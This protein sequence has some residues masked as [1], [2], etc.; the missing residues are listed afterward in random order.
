MSKR[1]VLCTD[2][3]WDNTGNDTNVYKVST[4]VLNTGDQVAFYDDGVGANG[5]IIEKLAGGALGA[6]LFQK[7][8]DGYTQIA[9]LYEQDDPIFLF[10]FSRGAYTARSLAGMIAICGLPTKNFDSNMVDLAFQAYRNTNAAQRAALLAQLNQSYEMYDAKI[11][12]LGVW[13]TVG[14]LGI[15]AIFG[16]VDSLIYGFLD[17]GLHP[18]VKNAFQALAID[19]RRIEFPPTLW[20]SQP[21]ADQ[22]LEQIWFTG[23]HC[24]VGGGYADD[25]STGTALSDITLSWMMSKAWALGLETDAGFEKQYSNLD[26][27][28]ALDTKHESW[29]VLWGFPKPRSVASDS[30]LANSVVIRYYNDSSYRPGNVSFPNGAPAPG[31]TIVPVVAAAPAGAAQAAAS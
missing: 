17:T 9:H 10:G 3:T 28:Y 24:D 14:S 30:S 19:E 22:I 2:G 15:P 6:G 1:I 11:T 4:G 27:K 18:D 13:D 7:I 26:A 21:A 20:T 31:Y 29:N 8:K 12:M 5:T 16:G 25:P 23:V